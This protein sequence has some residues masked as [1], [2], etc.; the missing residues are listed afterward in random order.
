MP[1]FNVFPEMFLRNKYTKK[2]HENCGFA[3]VIIYDNFLNIVD[4]NSNGIVHSK[5][6]FRI[7][8]KDNFSLKI[9]N[10]KNE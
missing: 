1:I 5:G 6:A 2:D 8:L 10:Y 3:A 7:N 9:L 4:V